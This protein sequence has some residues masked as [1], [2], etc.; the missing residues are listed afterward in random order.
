MT[1]HPRIEAGLPGKLVGRLVGRL[2][3]GLIRA[4][5]LLLSPFLPASCR[6]YPSCSAYGAEA[7]ARHGALAG[8]WLTLRRI[9][10]CH[11]WGGMG[12]D[13]V[14]ERSPLAGLV[15]GLAARHRCPGPKHRPEER[16]PDTAL[17][18]EHPE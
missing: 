12:L 9:L 8:L 3:I 2:L 11:P 13:P 14:P 6:Y 4:Y 18:W 17:S 16:R 5:Q 7:I 1:R 15:G 10:R